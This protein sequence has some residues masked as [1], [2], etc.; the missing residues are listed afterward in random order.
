MGFFS[1]ECVRCHL[2]ATPNADWSQRIV[3]I[4]RDG[5]LFKGDYDGYGRIEDIELMEYEPFSLYHELCW[6]L[7]DRPGKF[8]QE[9][10][11]AGDQ[12]YFCYEPDYQLDEYGR[13]KIR[14]KP[15]YHT[16]LGR[17]A[18]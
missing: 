10:P 14:N 15:A 16:I 2:S 12:G 11:A 1:W 4:T 9:S 17:R 18:G 3:V 8:T 5:Q 7:V 6:N 13:P